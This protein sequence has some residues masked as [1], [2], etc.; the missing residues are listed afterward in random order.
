MRRHEQFGRLLLSGSPGL[1]DDIM[2]DFDTLVTDGDARS[3][4]EL[5]DVVFVRAA[6][7]ASP[8]LGGVAK[9]RADRDRTPLTVTRE[10]THLCMIARSW[11]LRTHGFGT[12]GI[13]VLAPV[14]LP[15][16]SVSGRRSSLPVQQVIFEPPSDSFTPPSR[17]V[18]RKCE[19]PPRRSVRP[20][21]ASLS[22]RRDDLR[23]ST[24]RLASA[25]RH[26]S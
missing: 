10:V 26:R 5:E 6:E 23:H 9:L 17:K 3:L 24:D 11:P 4:D 12:S 7:A 25:V 13:V 18:M 15:R 21:W 14:R 16:R 20:A 1:S 8:D 22:K 19:K 2:E